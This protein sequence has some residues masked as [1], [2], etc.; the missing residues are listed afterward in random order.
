[1]LARSSAGRITPLVPF[2]VRV[3]CRIHVA[4]KLNAHRTVTAGATRRWPRLNAGSRL[5]VEMPMTGVRHF[6][7]GAAAVKR[8]DQSDGV[9]GWLKAHFFRRV[10]T[11]ARSFGPA[12][13]PIHQPVLAAA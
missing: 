3:V 5:Q 7:A 6:R 10:G 2:T 8:A 4:V 12:G 1:M 13:V 11:S 9:K